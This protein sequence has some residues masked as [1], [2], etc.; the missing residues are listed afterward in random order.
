MPLVFGDHGPDF[1]KLPDLV[2]QWF[3]IGS[4][5]WLGTTAAMAGQAGNHG[6]TPVGRNQGPFVLGVSGLPTRVPL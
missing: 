5:Q 6:L 2:A 4:V 3:G 1:G